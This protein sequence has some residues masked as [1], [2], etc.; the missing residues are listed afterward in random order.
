MKKMLALLLAG[1][2]LLSAC[3]QKAPAEATDTAEATG[4]GETQSESEDT[5]ED[6]QMLAKDKQYKILFI[7]NSY[8]FYNDMPTAYFQ[9]MATACGYDVEVATITKG[10]YTMEKFADPSD[11]YGQMVANAL[12]QK[13]LYDYVI[14]QEQSVRPASNPEAFY[15]GARKLVD[16][17]RQTGAQPVLYATWGRQTGSDKLTELNMTNETMSWALAAAYATIGKELDVPVYYAGLAFLD[18]NTDTKIDLYDADKS[19]PSYVGSYLAAMVLFCGIFEIDPL[20]AA[21]SGPVAEDM[22]AVL[23]QAAAKVLAETPAI[24]EEYMQTAASANT[25]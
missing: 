15:A 20:T 19:H 3:G 25:Q 9:T 17:V 14:L 10:A 21:F 13:D 11:A 18:V 16:M 7:G 23:R 12:S 6:T 1:V 2:L 22:D 4:T 8:T 24:P 5:K